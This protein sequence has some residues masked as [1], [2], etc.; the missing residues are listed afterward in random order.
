MYCNQ[1]LADTYSQS[2]AYTRVAG[3]RPDDLKNLYKFMF[4]G[5]DFATGHE[6]LRL[7][8]TGAYVFAFVCMIFGVLVLPNV[9]GASQGPA[10]TPPKLML[11]LGASTLTL[12]AANVGFSI[13]DR[14]DATCWE[15]EYE[16][17]AFDLIELC[18]EN[19]CMLT[20]NS[21]KR[22][23]TLYVASLCIVLTIVMFCFCTFEIGGGKIGVVVPA[24]AFMLV[25]TWNLSKAMEDDDEDPSN[26][27]TIPTLGIF[28]VATGLALYGLSTML[29]AWPQKLTL[30]TGFIFS[31]DAAFNLAKAWHKTSRCTTFCKQVID[32]HWDSDASPHVQA[33]REQDGS[34]NVMYSDLQREDTARS[35]SP[36]MRH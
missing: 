36:L 14:F 24:F 5:M 28:I 8:M 29:I 13:R 11:L 16:D 20:L 6:W 21:L 31:V 18:L 35:S 27:Y 25:S 33:M 17:S 26:N 32:W 1:D 2:Q 23:K 22:K 10:L 30:L 4:M 34:H 19:V 9:P 12:S 15:E 7:G 3:N